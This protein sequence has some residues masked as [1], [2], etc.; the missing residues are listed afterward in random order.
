ML[1]YLAIQDVFCIVF[2]K[3][4]TSIIAK[5][6]DAFLLCTFVGPFMWIPALIYPTI[7]IVLIYLIQKRRKLELKSSLIP[8]S[9]IFYSIV[10]VF[11]NYVFKIFKRGAEPWKFIL[12]AAISCILGYLYSKYI[13]PNKANAADAKIRAAD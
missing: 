10:L 3:P 13:I 1:C 11:S 9:I 7:F 5:P 6:L 2:T 4:G 8:S 12:I